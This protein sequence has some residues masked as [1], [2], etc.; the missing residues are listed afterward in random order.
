M[1]T[2]T[3][4]PDDKNGFQ[5]RESKPGGGGHITTGFP[6]REAAQAWIADQQR[7]AEAAD[8][9]AAPGYARRQ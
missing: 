6:S 4:E 3:I 1:S 2:Y 7:M 9:W 8:R 5:I